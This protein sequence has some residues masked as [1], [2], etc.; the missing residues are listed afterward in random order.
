MRRICPIDFQ[1]SKPAALQVSRPRCR[2]PACKPHTEQRSKRSF[3][4]CIFCLV[5]HREILA[6]PVSA[7]VSNIWLQRAMVA[8]PDCTGGPA[9]WPAGYPRVGEGELAC[10]GPCLQVWGPL[11]HPLQPSSVGPCVLPELN[12]FRMFGGSEPWLRPRIALEGQ[13]TGQRASRG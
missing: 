8:T 5:G 10:C 6:A 7:K 12:K 9:N 2:Q 13:Q 1:H 4:P 3:E 11:I